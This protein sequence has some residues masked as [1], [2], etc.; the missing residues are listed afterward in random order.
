MATKAVREG[1]ET[2][3]SQGHNEPRALIK[4]PSHCFEAWTMDGFSSWLLKAEK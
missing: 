3:K 2:H 4:P 1:E